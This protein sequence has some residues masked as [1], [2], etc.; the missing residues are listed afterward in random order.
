VNGVLVDSSVVID[1]ANRSSAWFAWSAER[2]EAL[3]G[4][5]ELL[6]NQIVFAESVLAFRSRG[7][8]RLDT[9]SIFKRRDLPWQAAALAGQAHAE[10]RRRGGLREAILADLLIAA[11]AE[12]EGLTL[13]TRDPVR[14]RAVFPNLLVVSPQV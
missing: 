5:A 9:D 7:D 14:A 1:I 11:H 2:L 8:D 12:A 6:I 4:E 10:Y 13:L 3:G